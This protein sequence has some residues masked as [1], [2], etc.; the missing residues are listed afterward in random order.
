MIV[1]SQCSSVDTGL[2]VTFKQR[3]Y[4]LSQQ[5]IE[6]QPR[7]GRFTEPVGDGGGGIERVWVGRI[8]DEG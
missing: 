6:R 4:P 2:F 1:S 5:V 3:G 8:K 7:R